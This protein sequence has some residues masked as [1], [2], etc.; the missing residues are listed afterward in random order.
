MRKNKIPGENPVPV[1]FCPP[2]VPNRLAWD[3]T[4]APA[5]SG[6]RLLALCTAVFFH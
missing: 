5:V 2:Q 3:R 4:W 6:R 1:S